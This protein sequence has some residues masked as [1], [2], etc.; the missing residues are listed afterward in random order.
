MMFPEFINAITNINTDVVITFIWLMT[1][2]SLVFGPLF[3]L[4]TDYFDNMDPEWDYSYNFELPDDLELDAPIGFHDPVCGFMPFF[5]H[6]DGIVPELN[7][8]ESAR[9]ARVEAEALLERSIKR[10]PETKAIKVLESARQALSDAWKW[11][12]PENRYFQNERVAKALIPATGDWYIACEPDWFNEYTVV[13]VYSLI[14]AS[15]W[16]DDGE[17]LPF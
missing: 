10:F 8:L 16:Y 1:G 9:A 17:Y 7:P 4:I 5:D 3:A 12:K 2:L 11:I 13:P 14:E 15:E 6:A